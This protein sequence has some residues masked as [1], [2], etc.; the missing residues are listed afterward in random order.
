MR[1]AGRLDPWQSQLRDGARPEKMEISS[2]DVLVLD[3]GAEAWST[4]LE[5][6]AL[7]PGGAFVA[8]LEL[9]SLHGRPVQ[10]FAQAFSRKPTLTFD[11]S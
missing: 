9:E 11:P 8:C 7:S 4:C 5:S 2:R 10:E 3:C 6:P 1:T